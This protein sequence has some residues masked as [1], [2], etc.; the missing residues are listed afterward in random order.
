[1]CVHHSGGWRLLVIPP[2]LQASLST[3]QALHTCLWHGIVLARL[4]STG[5]AHRVRVP[6]SEYGLCAPD[7][8]TLGRWQSTSPA[9]PT[10][11]TQCG[12]L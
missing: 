7:P 11:G 6:G 8:L 4:T 9:P 2:Q 12:H 10:S 5:A 3:Q 1:M